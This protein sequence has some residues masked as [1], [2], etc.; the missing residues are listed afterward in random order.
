MCVEAQLNSIQ[1]VC[2]QSGKIPVMSVWVTD[3]ARTDHCS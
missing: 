3:A 2:Y 1:P